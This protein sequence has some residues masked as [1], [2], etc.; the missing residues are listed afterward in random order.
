MAREFLFSLSGAFA[1]AGPAR[2][3]IKAACAKGSVASNRHLAR[4]YTLLYCFPTDSIDKFDLLRQ[5]QPLPRQL[6]VHLFKMFRADEHC[7]PLALGG[8]FLVPLGPFAHGA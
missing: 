7:L 8:L 4:G 2:Y 5:L 3:S 1:D 6:K